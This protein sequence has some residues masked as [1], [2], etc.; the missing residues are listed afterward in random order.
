MKLIEVSQSTLFI[1]CK[2]HVVGFS[3]STSTTP[4]RVYR[5]DQGR[6]SQIFSLTISGTDKLYAL[7]D[8][9]VVA[10]WDIATGQ[11]VSSKLLK[12]RAVSLICGSVQVGATSN[13]VVITADKVGDIIAHKSPS[14]D[15]EVLLGGHTASTITDIAIS[16]DQT[17][18]LSA[19]RDEKIRI[20]S[21]PA[22]ETI[23][24]YCLGH[25]S[26]VSSVSTLVL[27]GRQVIV[28]SGWDHKVHVWK[29]WPGTLSPVATASFDNSSTQSAVPVEDNV[30]EDSKLEDEQAEEDDMPAEK[31][32]VEAEAG[33]YPFKITTTTSDQITALA[34]VI[35]RGL[36][37]VKLLRIQGESVQEC[38]SVDLPASP[39]DI[40]FLS[41]EKLQVLLPKP[42]STVLFAISG[43]GSEVTVKDV[44]EEM[45][46]VVQYLQSTEH[47]SFSQ[48]LV[49]H[50]VGFETETGKGN[51]FFMHIH[52][53]PFTLC[54]LYRNE[55]TQFG[56]TLQ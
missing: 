25:T 56:Q 44:T 6:D 53:S 52:Y 1:A 41:P 32:Y 12:K 40:I 47:G 55:E 24:S 2:D 38:G 18:L 30:E 26:V 35:F 31:Q 33:H 46:S 39:A 54:V 27:E 50:A 21:F 4:P 8:N 28:S 36:S 48:D 10:V 43:V 20:S 22:V 45:A 11:L 9:K 51:M 23:Q 49:A 13:E 15:K 42:H 14:L 16:Q 7:F 17:L 34:A 37:V 3:L 5:A 19:D 29:Y